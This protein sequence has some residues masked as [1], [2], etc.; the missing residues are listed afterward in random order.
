MQTLTLERTDAAALPFILA[1]EAQARAQ[2]FV[3]GWDEAGHRRALETPG[4]V[5]FLLVATD[6]G[7]RVGYAIV[8]GLGPRPDSVELKR[9][10]VTDTGRGHGRAALRLIKTL[11][12]EEYGAHRL[13]LDAFVDNA[14][15]RHLYLSEGFVEEGVMRESARRA[16]G[17]A[18][19]VLMSILEQEY[20]RQ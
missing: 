14:R 17:Y 7:R 4:T 11:V 19:Q 16:D 12:F 5:Y 10:V 1:A 3:S 13:W 20:S 18:S 9:L 8:R 2:G 6:D 15:A